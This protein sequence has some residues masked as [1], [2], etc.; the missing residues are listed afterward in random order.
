MANTQINLNGYQMKIKD[1]GDGTYSTTICSPVQE[2]TAFNALAIIDTVNHDVTI[3]VSNLSGRKV[4]L[5]CNTHNQAVTVS[6]I[7]ATSSGTSC[8]TL[9]SKSVA[10]TSYALISA[11][12]IATLVEPFMKLTVRTQCSVAPTSGNVTVWLEGVSA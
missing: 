7:A 10:A 9:G 2:V 11:A 4:F 12:D 3:D 8:V 6:I 1:N 5:V